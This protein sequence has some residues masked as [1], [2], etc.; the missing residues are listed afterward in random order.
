MVAAWWT[1][2][3]VLLTTVS[4]YRTS[5]FFFFAPVP[6][7]PRRA[8]GACNFAFDAMFWLVFA[9]LVLGAL[10]YSVA[11]RLAALPVA[12]VTVELP[13][14]VELFRV[15]DE[16]AADYRAWLDAGLEPALYVNRSLA[17]A[18]PK[19]YD[20]TVL[21]E[22][23]HQGA[24]RIASADDDAPVTYFVA[25]CP[26]TFTPDSV[27]AVVARWCVC[28]L[29]R[30]QHRRPTTQRRLLKVNRAT[31]KSIYYCS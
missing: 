8:R 3:K 4:H 29:N 1:F 20:V 28:V 10:G 18:F 17:R 9:V 15:T 21:R 22:M 25:Q 14:P 24:V 19:D 23:T 31:P 27:D 13:T 30:L 16:L 26:R 5:A 12:T 11:R 2:S 6:A 7:R